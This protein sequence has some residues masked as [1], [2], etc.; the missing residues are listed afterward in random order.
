MFFSLISTICRIILI[1]EDI[2]SSM[3]FIKLIALFLITFIL[4]CSV[5]YIFNSQNEKVEIV[6]SNSSHSYVND[7]NVKNEDNENDAN[8]GLKK[9]YNRKKKSR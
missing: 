5:K 3:I 8:K 9:K 7:V 2:I 1:N 6:K 4:F